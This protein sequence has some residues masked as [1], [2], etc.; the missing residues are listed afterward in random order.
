MNDKTAKESG[1]PAP[2]SNEVRARQSGIGQR[3]RQMYDDVVNEPVPDDFAD[4]LAKIEKSKSD[5]SKSGQ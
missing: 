5:K 1:K 2:D 4:L 3:L